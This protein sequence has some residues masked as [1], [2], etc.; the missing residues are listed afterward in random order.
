MLRYN[1]IIVLLI[2]LTIV[3]AILSFNFFQQKKANLNPIFASQSAGRLLSEQNIGG[4]SIELS[5]NRR[6]S[7]HEGY[8]RK[9][10]WL[11]NVLWAAGSAPIT[12]DQRNIYITMPQ[13]RYHYDPDNNSLSN[14]SS[15]NSDDAAFVLDY[16][17]KPEFDA[18]VSYMSPSLSVS[19]W[20]GTKSQLVS[21]PKQE[22]LYFGIMDLE[23][24]TDE[25][26]V[27]SFDGSLPD[28]GT[29]GNNSVHDVIRDL[30][31]SSEF[32]KE[33]IS[34]EDLSQIL[35]AGYGNTP[36]MTYNGRGGL[37]VPSWYADY[38]LTGNIYIVKQ[39]GVFRYHN[40]NPDGDLTTRDHRLEKVKNDDIRALLR[41]DISG[42][43][44]APCY[45][46]LSLDNDDIDKWYVR[47]E[48]GFVAGK[49]CY[50]GRRWVLGAGLQGI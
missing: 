47:L 49:W 21:C 46:I 5:L 14:R 35:W 4:N 43:P 8:E 15:D 45:S 37:T 17:G 11:S 50:R 34:L 30:K 18:G 40:R 20:N 27:R 6:E 22:K 39:D 19:M 31:Y 3:M 2:I 32:K 36:H 48:A 44:D 16:D 42:L 24:L 25:L 38:Y 1:E 9:A 29:R 26:A 33:D 13:G 28:P 23:G 12:D 7:Y 10:P 41:S